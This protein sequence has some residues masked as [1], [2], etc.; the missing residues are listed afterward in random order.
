MT[1]G[2]VYFSL[3]VSHPGAD[4]AL[5]WERSPLAPLRD[6]LRGCG[7]FDRLLQDDDDHVE[8]GTT[9]ADFLA[10]LE[11]RSDEGQTFCQREPA[12]GR[13]SPR[14]RVRGALTEWSEHHELLF[15]LIYAAAAASS[16]GSQARLSVMGDLEG[17]VV[18]VL[19]DV[20]GGEVRVRQE[21]PQNLSEAAW[22]ERLGGMAAL[23]EARRRWMKK[24]RRRGE[25]P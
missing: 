2:V 25:R 7:H 20:T 16:T 15:P 11:R 1:E 3:E 12:H 10:R 24:R 22:E 8:A 19:V 23:E 5:S 17:T 18:L 13:A 21:D 6:A 4:V 9:V 14:V